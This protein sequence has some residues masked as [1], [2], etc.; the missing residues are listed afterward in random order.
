MTGAPGALPSHQG[1]F[2]AVPPF[3]IGIPSEVLFNFLKIDLIS[4]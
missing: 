4:I 2:A 1:Q 3:E